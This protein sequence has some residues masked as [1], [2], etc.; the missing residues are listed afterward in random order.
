MIDLLSPGHFYLVIL[1]ISVIGYYCHI[2]EDFKISFFAFLE[3]RA[4]PLM[5]QI[6][7]WVSNKSFNTY[8]P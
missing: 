7:V 4:S 1:E 2:F 3:R 6:K 5:N 8:I